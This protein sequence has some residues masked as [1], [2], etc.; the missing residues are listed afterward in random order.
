VHSTGADESVTARVRRGLR[1]AAEQV[2]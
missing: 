1:A 2:S